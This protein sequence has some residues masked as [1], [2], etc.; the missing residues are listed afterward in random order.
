MARH[1]KSRSI[2]RQSGSTGSAGLIQTVSM[3]S[4]GALAAGILGTIATVGWT[5]QGVGNAFYYWQ[6]REEPPTL[7]CIAEVR[8]DLAASY[9]SW[10]QCREGGWRS[11]A[12]LVRKN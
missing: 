10:P 8:S 4:R 1:A 2:L 11:L 3:Y 12:V 5:L 9:C 7:F 6:V